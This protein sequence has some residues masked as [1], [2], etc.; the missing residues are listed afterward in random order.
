MSKEQI[1]LITIAPKS[2]LDDVWDYLSLNG[3]E[4]LYSEE[5]GLEKKIYAQ[6]SS[7]ILNHPAIRS[8]IPY[9]MPEINWDAQWDGKESL[10]LAKYGFQDKTIKM[11]PGAGFGDL[12]HPTTSLVCQI[13]APLVAGKKILDIGSGSGILSFA[14]MAMGASECVGIEIDPEAIAHA[15]INAELNGYQIP[16]LLPEQLPHYNPDVILMNM[17]T[18]EQKDAWASLSNQNKIQLQNTTYLITSGVL[19]EE[20][21][22]YLKWA[23]SEGWELQQSVEEEGWAGFLLSC[24]G[25]VH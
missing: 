21:A 18:S 3:G 16:F 7:D 6:C 15:K 2:S 12:S 17:I 10:S 11:A 13:M 1:Y 22:P 9:E 19:V 25:V 14:A 23:Y 8:F 4:L 20:K 5:E 24:R